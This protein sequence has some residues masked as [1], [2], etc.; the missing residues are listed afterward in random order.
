MPLF[1]A[2]LDTEWEFYIKFWKI[3]FW[4]RDFAHLGQKLDQNWTEWPNH[5]KK[6]RK[7]N[8]TI[9]PYGF[10][11][12][13]QISHEVL[14]NGLLKERLADLGLKLVQISPKCPN[15]YIIMHF[16]SPQI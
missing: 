5:I 15:L 8:E 7:P 14:K 9:F 12:W 1:H 11:H 4:R 10:G 2:V 13:G 16:K 6:L 3:V